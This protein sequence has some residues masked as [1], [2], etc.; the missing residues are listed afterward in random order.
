MRRLSQNRLA[1]VDSTVAYLVQ[2]EPIWNSNPAFVKAVV[3]LKKK[4]AA[5]AATSSKYPAAISS[6]AE[7]AHG[8]EL[9]EDLTAEIADQLFAL[10]TETSDLQLAAAADVSRASLDALTDQQLE[11]VAKRI[12]E[13]ATAHRSALTRYLVVAADVAELAT[14]TRNFSTW[15]ATANECAA[16]SLT[17]EELVR[18][19]CQILRGRIDKLVTRYARTAP[20]FV[21][22]YHGARVVLSGAPT[23]DP[24]TPIAANDI[25]TAR[26]EFAYA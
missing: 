16:A 15:P 9:L 2:N 21:R 17:L 8:R 3:D 24:S 13:L 6:A 4:L 11:H 14:L 12:C 7:R 5:I 20:Q 23:L 26:P 19:A 10:A 18:G 22:G 1:M 25:V